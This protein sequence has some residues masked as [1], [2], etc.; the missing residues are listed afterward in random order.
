VEFFEG[1][2]SAERESFEN[3]GCNFPPGPDDEEQDY[4]D[5]LAASRAK[6]MRAPEC[7]R[8]PMLP[9]L[10]R[11]VALRRHIERLLLAK[12][13]QLTKGYLTNWFFDVSLSL[14]CV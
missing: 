6:S 7:S 9:R 4:W 8:S 11:C 13:S 1:C 10:S 3:T 14:I 2:A 5:I 12:M